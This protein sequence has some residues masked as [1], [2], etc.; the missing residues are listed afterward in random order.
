V[1]IRESREKLLDAA[2]LEVY[3]NGYHGAS[4][5]AILK[6]AGVP[7]GSMYHFF[8]S[9][10]GL[11]LATIKERIFP[12]IDIFF[13]FTMDEDRDISQT[14]ESIFAKM[15]EHTFLIKSGCPLHRL[16]VEM[17][18]LDSEFEYILNSKFDDFVK[19]LSNLFNVSIEKSELK[20]FDTYTMARFFITSTW[21]EISLSPSI[22]SK[23]SFLQHSRYL[24]VLLRCYQR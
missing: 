18:P 22:S 14:M 16:M 20:D 21:G 9:K 24:T 13:D 7:K 15:S 3:K 1:R 17:A 2:F 5:A 23:K 11:I 6:N 8:N 10:K 12:K 4:T 19:N